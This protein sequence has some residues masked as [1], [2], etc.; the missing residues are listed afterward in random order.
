MVKPSPE[1]GGSVLLHYDP[2]IA[3]VLQSMTEDSA[4]QGEGALWALYDAISAKTLLLR[5]A[6]SDL[7]S[8]DTARQMTLRGPQAQLLEFSGV[9]HAPTLVAP[10]Q[11]APVL[12]FLMQ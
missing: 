2:A 12:D 7:L 10:E 5:G 9:G 11:L 1:H 4:R 8:L 3:V 6:Q